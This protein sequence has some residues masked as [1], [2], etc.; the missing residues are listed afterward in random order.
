[1]YFPLEHGFRIGKISEA[2]TLKNKTLVVR[3]GVEIILIVTYD[4][5]SHLSRGCFSDRYFGDTLKQPTTPRLQSV[6][7]IVAYAR[8]SFSPHVQTIYHPNSWL[9]DS[10]EAGGNSLLIECFRDAWK[11][12]GLTH[13]FSPDEPDIKA[14]LDFLKLPSRAAKPPGAESDASTRYQRNYRNAS[15]PNNWPTVSVSRFV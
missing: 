10:D 1:M 6:G 15:P 5:P 8:M 12:S 9:Y 11:Q 13:T 7:L 4:P 3:K 2:H 14:A